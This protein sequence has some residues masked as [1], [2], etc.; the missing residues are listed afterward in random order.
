MVV[1][2]APIRGRISVVKN[3]LP[4]YD[5]EWGQTTRTTRNYFYKKAQGIFKFLEL[6]WLYV[7]AHQ[8]KNTF[9]FFQKSIP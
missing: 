5:P 8:L 3:M 2:F 1:E 4:I 9:V 6:F 7:V